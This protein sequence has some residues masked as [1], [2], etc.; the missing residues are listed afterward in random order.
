MFNLLQKFRMI[1]GGRIIAALSAC[2]LA[3]PVANPAAAYDQICFSQRTVYVTNGI[4][5]R[6][7]SR[8]DPEKVVWSH[9]IKPVIYRGRRECMD[10]RGK[11]NPGDPFNIVQDIM[12]GPDRRCAPNGGLAHGTAHW[13]AGGGVLELEGHGPFY[14]GRCVI[15]SRRMWAGCAD[16]SLGGFGQV[17]CGDWLPELHQYAAYDNVYN[18][19]TLAHLRSVLNRGADP[20]VGRSGGQGTPLHVAI[21]HW[22]K[23]H[24]DAL[25]SAGADP[26]LKDGKGNSAF[27]TLLTDHGHREDSLHAF[28]RMLRGRAAPDKAR[29]INEGLTARGVPAMI[30]VVLTGNPDLV[31]FALEQ[32]GDVNATTY[33]R[34]SALHHAA[35]R[36]LRMVRL[37]LKKGADPNVATRGGFGT[38]LH[39]TVDPRFA[40]KPLADG[41]RSDMVGAMLRAGGDPNATNRNGQTPLHFAAQT[42]ESAAVGGMLR[43]GGDPNAANERGQ[44]PLHF[45]AKRGAAVGHMLNYGGDPNR[46]DS[47]GMTALHYAAAAG[48]ARMME[49]LI[50]GGADPSLKDNNGNTAEELA[51]R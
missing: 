23:D 26:M 38:P 24:M 31:E 37:L 28:E 1:S 20:N 36:S 25:L 19:R 15:A 47:N 21:H 4:Y 48:H 51:S 30:N 22:R 9:R 43:A 33:S 16:D 27:W 29:M 12:S 10:V 45:A 32:G 7:V 50:K 44:T 8:T 49:Q 18:G 35:R 3:A 17:G 34:Y 5:L 46:A 42:G 13:P 41:M 39:W 6:K 11:L 14:D 40:D 2:A